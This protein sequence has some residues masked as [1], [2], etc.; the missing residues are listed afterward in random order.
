VSAIFGFYVLAIL[1]GIV[2]APS[3]G[4][5]TLALVLAGSA[6]ATPWFLPPTWVVARTFYGIGGFICIAGVLDVVRE[7]RA[8]STPERLLRVVFFVD[9]RAARPTRRTIDLRL[10]AV[11]MAYQGVGLGGL[12]AIVVGAPSLHGPAHWGLR[13]GGGMLFCYVQPEI[14]RAVVVFGGRAIGLEPPEIHR[15]PILSATI[16]EFWGVRWN[17]PVGAWL[18][19]H[20]FEPLAQRGLPNLGVLA[21]FAMSAALHA[22]FTW[23]AVGGM[24]ALVMLAFFLLQGLLVVVER[25][26]GVA[27]WPSRSGRAWTIS[28]MV[29]T[30]PLFVEP[31]LR[32]IGI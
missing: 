14:A 1:A 24:L 2:A 19:F 5:A 13:W 21:A 4:R 27:R 30:S 15:T 11:T 26:V 31:M 8:W 29:A 32:C 6:A 22:Y 28:A 9:L 20:G 17:R 12:W 18:R 3:R 25:A 23:V 10:A 16:R 7:R